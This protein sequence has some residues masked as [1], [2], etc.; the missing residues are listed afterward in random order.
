MAAHVFTALEILEK[1]LLAVKFDQRQL[2][3]VGL[4][5]NL[6]R[7]RSNYVGHPRVHA[8]LFEMLQETGLLDCS[9]LGL[10]KSL[11]CFFVGVH[12]LA[13]HPTEEESECDNMTS[14]DALHR[15]ASTSTSA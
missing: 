13:Q 5:K 6:S 12:L 4:K 2:D 1:G 7:F 10:E 11:N 3:R 8:I 15:F 14:F 9:I